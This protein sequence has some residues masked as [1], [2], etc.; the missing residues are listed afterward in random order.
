MLDQITNRLPD[1]KILQS[2]SVFI[3]STTC[4]AGTISTT[5]TVRNSQTLPAYEKAL[6]T[7][8]KTTQNSSASGRLRDVA[9]PYMA[10]LPLIIGLATARAGAIVASYGSY[11]KTDEG[12]FSDGTMMLMLGVLLVFFVFITATKHT[13]KQRTVNALMYGC[14]ALEVLTLAALSAF[15]FRNLTDETLNM[16]FVLCGLCNLSAAGGIFYWLRCM[17]GAGAGLV[18][19]FAFSALILSEIELYVCTLLPPL[20]AKL[21]VAALA[22]TQLPCIFKARR[23]DSRAN[24]KQTAL[25]NDYFAFAKTMLSSR[26]FLIAT[27]IG[28]G[29]LSLVIGFLRGYPDGTSIS[30]TPLTRAL[31][32]LL[33]F[34][35]SVIIIVLAARKVHHVMTSTIF[36][37]MEALACVA[38]ICYAAFPN[39][40]QVGAVFATTLNAIMMTFTWYVI[41]AFM[42]SGWRDPYYYAIAGQFVYLGGRSIA[43]VVLLSIPP[44]AENPILV[45]AITGALVVVSTQV[46]LMQF[47][48]IMGRQHRER[49]HLWALIEDA[50]QSAPD[51]APRIGD[52][53][54]SGSSGKPIGSGDSVLMRVMGLDEAGSMADMRQA[55]M[56]HSIQELGRQFLLS[57]REVEVLTLYAQGFTQKR[58]AEELFISQGTA[59]AH[60]KRIYAKTGLHSRQEIIDY[61][62]KYTS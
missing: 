59:H 8:S 7:S 21:A 12:M 13:L 38:L 24:A 40:L 27:A 45:G 28:I 14:I 54:G 26:N 23:I 39:A 11:A 3:V 5:L 51:K 42:T 2:C 25:G 6:M 34:A 46:I 17:R 33:T 56:Q 29:F 48:K 60:I 49:E 62:Q 1:C 47:L 20:V 41:V 18:V 58:V 16:R 15:D 44:L 57:E 37:L 52:M 31:Y 22:A 32:P 55:A 10:L 43:R 61:L 35:I 19:A 50:Q 4:T 9:A 36:I 30:F 53:G